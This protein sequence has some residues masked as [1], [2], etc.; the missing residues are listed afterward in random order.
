MK[1]KGGVK[2]G[3]CSPVNI[4]KVTNL[5][6]TFV[7]GENGFEYSA[8]KY[9]VSR[10]QFITSVIAVLYKL[11]DKF[12]SNFGMEPAPIELHDGY[13]LGTDLGASK[14][15]ILLPSHSSYHKEAPPLSVVDDVLPLSWQ[16]RAYE[17][18]VEER[19]GRP[20]GTYLPLT[21]IQSTSI[22]PEMVSCRDRIFFLS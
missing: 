22:T 4:I 20:W 2:E 18:A 16:V 21:M 9:A 17:L 1:T 13:F 5:L 12:I 3:Y 7:S 14:Q 8:F 15:Q 10:A 6:L 11:Y 19:K